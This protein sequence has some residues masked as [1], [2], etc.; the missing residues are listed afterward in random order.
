M[1]STRSYH[2]LSERFSME[3]DEALFQEHFERAVMSDWTSLEARLELNS[4]KSLCR[5]NRLL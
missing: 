3:E 1:I 2:N 5:W 4:G